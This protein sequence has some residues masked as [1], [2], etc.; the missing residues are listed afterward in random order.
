M[1]SRVKKR[2]GMKDRVCLKADIV[3]RWDEVDAFPGNDIS[4]V[5][6]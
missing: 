1:R 6:L 3:W 5:L 4:E 2:A